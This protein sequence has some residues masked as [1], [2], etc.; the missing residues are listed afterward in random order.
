M[1]FN[2]C[3]NSKKERG[4]A[5]EGMV[6]LECFPILPG[7]PLLYVS[8][9]SLLLRFL[10]LVAFTATPGEGRADHTLPFLHFI[11]PLL[12]NTH[13]TPLT[14]FFIFFPQVFSLSSSVSYLHF[15]VGIDVSLSSH[16]FLLQFYFTFLYNES[17]EN[18]YPSLQFQD[19]I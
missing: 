8:V 6:L 5:L 15:R 9:A 14:P 18:V 11:L 16:H 4:A 19:N 2:R 17:I 3:R 12:G 1:K 13:P 10:Y 7:L